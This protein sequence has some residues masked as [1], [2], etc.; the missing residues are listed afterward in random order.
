LSIEDGGGG[1]EPPASGPS[2]P[3]DPRFNPLATAI[4][5][6]SAIA[7]PAVVFGYTRS[8]G[9][10]DTIIVVGV[11]VAIFVGILAGVWVAHRGGW[12]WRGP[13]M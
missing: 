8:S 4:G 2:K 12:V 9:P 10:D 1:T 6:F 5:V 3:P 11:L 7:A 13:R